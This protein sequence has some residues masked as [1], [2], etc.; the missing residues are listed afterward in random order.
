MMDTGDKC[1]KI[2]LRFKNLTR[3][4]IVSSRT[5][6]EPIC[7]GNIAFWDSEIEEIQNNA[8]S[9]VKTTYNFIIS[10]VRVNRVLK[11]AFSGMT[12]GHNH[13]GSLIIMKNSDIGQVSTHAFKDINI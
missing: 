2:N 1:L 11:N 4:T 9:Q 7:V 13:Q 10:N 5:S 8:F 3:G 12:I 6:S